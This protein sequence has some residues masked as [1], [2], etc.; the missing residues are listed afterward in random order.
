MEVEGSSPRAAAEDLVG[1]LAYADRTDRQIRVALQRSGLGEVLRDHEFSTLV[2]RGRAARKAVP[3]PRSNVLPRIIGVLA[4]LLGGFWIHSTT[5]KVALI[6]GLI[7]I[8]KPCWRDDQ[9]R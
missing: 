5:G 7:L 8:I 9:V 6:L 4:V 1:E 3:R 2:L